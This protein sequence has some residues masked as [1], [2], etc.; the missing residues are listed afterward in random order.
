M[1][2]R[3]II[4]IVGTLFATSSAY[5]QIATPGDPLAPPPP[6]PLVK[7]AEGHLASNLIGEN[8][9]NGTSA[10]A[11]NIGDV[12]DIVINPDGTVAA[13]VIGV[14]GFLG[15]GEK[16]VAIEYDLVEIGMV[17]ED[18]VLVVKTTAEALKA[19]E[20]FDSAAYVPM[21]ADMNVKET[22]P[23]T[24]EDLANAPMEPEAAPE[25]PS[26]AAAPEAPPEDTLPAQ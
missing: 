17:N 16:N 1:T 23:A 5:A 6:A 14:G 21:P 22:K 7:H 8:V 13:L 9:Y 18:E 3:L 11:E 15:I 20:E 24:A 4:A 12:N 10:E 2:R 25:N 26:A 19:Q